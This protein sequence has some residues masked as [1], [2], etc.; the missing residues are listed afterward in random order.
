M[1][2]LKMLLSLFA[3]V[4]V[5]TA[6]QAMHYEDRDC[7][8]SYNIMNGYINQVIL[9]EKRHNNTIITK[10]HCDLPKLDTTVSHCEYIKPELSHIAEEHYD[11]LVAI[12]EAVKYAK[13][14]SEIEAELKKMIALVC[15]NK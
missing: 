15:V 4:L 5:T 10:V 14:Y 3:I 9:N 11:D 2:K 1:K 6:S 13:K 7:V 12:E 8:H